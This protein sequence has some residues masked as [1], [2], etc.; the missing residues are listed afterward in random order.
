MEERDKKNE[1]LVG[2]F[3]TVG[4]VML[5]LLILQF[6]S[7]RD[8]FKGSYYLS[9]SFPNASGLKEASPVVL[10]GK[11][12]GKVKNKPRHNDTYTGVII[13]LEIFKG[14]K[15]PANSVFT[16]TT[17]GLMGD[18]YVDIDPPTNITDQFITETQETI[19]KG[20]EAGGLSDL[21]SAAER[22]G[23]QVSSVLEDDLK[24]ALGEIKEAMTKINQDALSK[25][26]IDKFKNGMAKLDSTLS[27]V[28]T[29]LLNDENSQNLKDAIAD[30]KEASAS[31]KNASKSIEDS[32]K[33][34]TP[35]I[36]K[37]DAP[38]SK[39]DK[40]MTSADEAIQAIKTAAADFSTTAKNITNSKGLL[41]ALINDQRLRADFHDLIYNMKVNG[42]V[43]YKNTA[44]KERARQEP[45]PAP[46]PPR[47][48]SL[49][50]N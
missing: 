37:L 4:L 16:I 15:I 25:E 27:R 40:V 41:G 34:L 17:A 35:L 22:I 49:F 20:Q 10:A 32:S 44:D 29:K 50:G 19:I 30:L 14:E 21:Q 12:I 31:F 46:Q 3:L 45:A 1:L 7:V 9:V 42:P 2:L 18:A 24:P 47:R 5:S 33:K 48:Q 43:L 6:G 8:L 38:I 11:R 26:T 39:A 28:D 23:K 13:D 36:D